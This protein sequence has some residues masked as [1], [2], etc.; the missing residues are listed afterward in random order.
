M[1]DVKGVWGVELFLFLLLVPFHF[2]LLFLLL[3]LFLFLF[4]FF[5][6]LCVVLLLSLFLFLFPLFDLTPQK[7]VFSKGLKTFP[8]SLCQ[9]ISAAAMHISQWRIH[10]RIWFIPHKGATATLPALRTLGAH[11]LLRRLTLVVARWGH[12]PP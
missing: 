11:D 12:R 6:F 8:V 7:R 10:T 1:P 4:I 5:F 3:P 9:R 2:L